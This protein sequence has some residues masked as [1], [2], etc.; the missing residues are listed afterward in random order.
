MPSTGRDPRAEFAETHIPGAQ[1]F[2][3]DAVCDTTSDLPHM[4]PNIDH[5][6]DAAGSF[7]IGH[8]TLVVVYD[9]PGSAAAARVWWMFRLFGHEAVAV[10][11]GGMAK[12]LAEGHPLTDDVKS[13]EATPFAAR[14]DRGRVRG[15]AE[16]LANLTNG[17]EIVVDNRDAG[18]FAGLAP[19]PRPA[20]KAGHIPGSRNLPFTDFFDAERL[21]VWRSDEEL[22]AVFQ[23]A[24]VDPGGPLVATCGSGVTACTTVLAAYL[25]GHDRAAVYDGSWAEWG[26][27]DDT[28]IEA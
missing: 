23:R 25:L 10:L 2:D 15:K 5:F 13:C 6:A 11:D 27:C 24:G 26:N 9:T 21:G 17:R 16:L 20:A 3:I 8:K 7:G 22:A 18:R 12:W 28:P 1:F 14:F 19:E 4:V